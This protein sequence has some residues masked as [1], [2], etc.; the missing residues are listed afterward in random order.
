MSK[1][2]FVNSTDF[3]ER[4]A[5]IRSLQIGLLSG[6]SVLFIGSPG[7]AKSLLVEAFAAGSGL[8]Y[9][10]WLLTKFTTPEEIFGALDLKALEQGHFQRNITGKLPDCEIGFVDEVFKA[11]SSILNSLLTIMQERL[12]FNNGTPVNVPLKLLVGASNELPD[13]E[14]LGALFDRFLIRNYVNYI[15]D[16]SSIKQIWANPPQI[17]T[18]PL[19]S[20]TE[21]EN[22]LEEVSHVEFSTEIQDIILI[23]KL[24]LENQ[25]IKASDRR[26]IKT[27]KILQATALTAG[28]SKVENEDLSFLTNI[29]W[30]TPDEIAKIRQIIGEKVLPHL[31]EIQKIE[32]VFT[33]IK[34][35]LQKFPPKEDK[36]YFQ[37]TMEVQQKIKTLIKQVEKVTEC[38]EKHQLLNKL[39]STGTELARQ[40]KGM[41]DIDLDEEK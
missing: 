24:E 5:E 6:E 40:L 39:S 3:P 29:L 2:S 28:R 18:V 10:R 11:S 32:D 38:P 41:I 23:L 16:Q 36:D 26:W 4:S 17:P 20:K 25:G 30:R 9:F 21:L 13:D 34:E 22:Q 1:L 35:N 37:K 8:S 14:G 19:I 31:A 27:K 33:P 7:T 12:F 15:S